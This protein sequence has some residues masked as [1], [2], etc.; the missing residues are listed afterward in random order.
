[1]TRV[2]NHEVA[3]AIDLGGTNLRAALVHQNGTLFHRRAIA[4]AAGRSTVRVVVQIADLVSEFRAYADQAGVTIRGVGMGIPGFIERK[5]GVVISS[6]NFPQWKG[7]EIG[8][9]LRRHIRLPFTIEND[10]NCAALGEW[11][12]GSARGNQDAICITLGTG[13]GGGIISNNQLV[14]GS[15][16]GAGEIGHIHIDFHGPSCG[17]GGH[18]CLESL[19]SGTALARRS[20]LRGESLSRAVRQGNLRAKSEFRRMGKMLGVAAS[21]LC[22]IFDPEVIVLGGRVV[23][24]FRLFYPSMKEEMRKR[25]KNHPSRSV[26]VVPA[27]CG[28]NAGLLGA[29]WLVFHPSDKENA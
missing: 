16:G 18:G 1:M 15:R 25:L 23:R 6:P 7:F 26:K 24:S 20:G 17:C 13:V 21:S 10:A 11:W 8:K 19:T 12:K 9:N 28:D 14:V 22:F 4:T 2:S 27:K 3:I 29:A 5:R